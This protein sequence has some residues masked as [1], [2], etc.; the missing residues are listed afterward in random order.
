MKKV[1]RILLNVPLPI[2]VIAASLMIAQQLIADGTYDAE[3]VR[4]FCNFRG[5]TEPATLWGKAISFE[6]YKAAVERRELLRGMHEDE[7]VEVMGGRPERVSRERR[8]DRT[9]TVWEY[10]SRA[11]DL[12]LD[13]G[14]LVDWRGPN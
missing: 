1:T 4:R 12:Y 8:M 11:L 5:D 13:D 14:F 10:R 9:Y 7:I 2:V 3:F 6:E